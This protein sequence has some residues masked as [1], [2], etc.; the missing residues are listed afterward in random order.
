MASHRVQVPSCCVNGIW[1]EG[2]ANSRAILQGVYSEI[3]TRSIF[4]SWVGHSF[5][6]L[7]RWPITS[8]TSI[9]LVTSPNAVYCPSRNVLSPVTMKNCEPALS[10]SSDLAMETTP[11]TWDFELNSAF[12]VYPGPPMPHLVLS[13]CLVFGS[14]PWITHPG[15]ILWKSSPS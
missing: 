6:P 8:A 3:V 10:G 13:G 7:G 15:T 4:A 14:P 12:M 11:L 5:L 2:F 9:P 1:R